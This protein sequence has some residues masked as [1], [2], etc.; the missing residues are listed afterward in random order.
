M[1]YWQT[2]NGTLVER[3]LWGWSNVYLVSFDGHDIMV[4]TGPA[5]FSGLLLKRLKETGLKQL[6][7]LV[8]THTHF[9][10][11]GSVAVLKE[12]Y[13]MPVIVHNTEA[14]YLET[15]LSP[16]PH[17]NIP[18]TRF[19]YKLGAP[20]VEHKFKVMGV[21][22]DVLADDVLDLTGFGINARLIHTPGHSMGSCSMLI[23]DQLAISGDTCVSP[24]PGRA[25]PPWADDAASL[26]KS[27]ERLLDTG[28]EL[29]L[30]MHHWTISR[31]TLLKEYERHSK[32]EVKGVVSR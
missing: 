12:K 2:R 31:E 27:W 30:P 10:H 14:H 20:R 17:G 22:G 16:L 28:C 7:A 24:F 19:L 25:F 29:F 9:D 3:I 21:A 23:D 6:D 15:G 4:D 26:L 8:L 13:N 11:T 32:K 5:A 1:R 18:L